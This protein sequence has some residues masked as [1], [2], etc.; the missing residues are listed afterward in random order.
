MTVD[1]ENSRLGIYIRGFINELYL[2]DLR[3]KTMRGLEGQK[4]RGFS[5][6]EN[7]Y[8]Y[9]TEPTGGLNLNKKGQ[10]KYEGIV[11]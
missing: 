5:T 8:G 3:R 7:A 6:G 11:Q 2:D 9:R 4:L 10:A 1:D